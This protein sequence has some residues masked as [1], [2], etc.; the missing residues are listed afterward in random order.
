MHR[1]TGKWITDSRFAPLQPKDCYGMKQVEQNGLEDSHILFRASFPYDGKGRVRL[2]WSADDCAKV[3]VNGVMATFGPAPGYPQH[4]YYQSL[5]IT[6]LLH[7]GKNVLAFHT[8]YQGMVNRVY[9]SGDFRHGLLF[10][11]TCGGKLLLSS[12]PGSV[13]VASHTGYTVSHIIGYHTQFMENYDSRSPQEGFEQPDYDDS[14]WES[15]SLREHADYVLYP[16]PAKALVTE[17][18]TAALTAREG[19]LLRFD[20]GQ[21]F[22]GNP[23]LKVTGKA[24]D[25]VEIRCGEELNPDGSVRYLMRCNCDYHEKWTLSGRCDV[26]D[27][28]DYK[29]FRYVEVILPE[30]AVLHEIYGLAR[31]YPFHTDVTFDR[32]ETLNA[33]VRLCIDTLHYGV[34]EGF[35]DCPSREKGQYFGDGVWSALSHLLLT[36]DR[37][38]FCKLLDNGLQSSEFVLAGGTAEGPCSLLQ[39]IAEYP[40]MLLP[41]LWYYEKQTG[42]HS[43]AVSRK[44]G[45]RSILACYAERYADESGLVSVY[46]RWNVVDWPASARDGYDF[47]LTE[48]KIIHGFHNVIN[49]YWLI[50]LKCY[51]KLYGE[52]APLPAARVAAAYRRAFYDAK[53][54]RFRDSTGSQ[55]TALASQV[56]GMLSGTVKDKRAGKVLETMIAEK[57]LSAS[58]LFVTPVMFLWLK[59]TGRDALLEDLIC[60]EGAWRNMLAEGATTTFEAFSR[61]KKDNCSLFHTMFAFPLVF[62]LPSKLW[63]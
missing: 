14:G 58:N 33:I 27:P 7:P 46:D 30:G 51:E 36:G 20:F 28:F 57:R 63:D 32:G 48:G 8:L 4:T 61:D 37:A 2:Y 31:H 5:D 43:F 47:D 13:R 49:A 62:L 12:C 9:C 26:Y 34:Q 11:L 17:K 35:L 3:Y 15:A 45:M 21:E 19:G 42:D 39:T 44:D 60:D 55:H 54:C 40:L 50:A 52:E 25:T 38:M 53:T 23:I 6:R 10:D 18:M 59:T 1:F 41:A 29:G 16:N 24:G 22:V 56:F